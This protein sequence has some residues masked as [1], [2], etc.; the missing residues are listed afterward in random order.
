MTKLI[1]QYFLPGVRWVAGLG[2]G[3]TVLVKAAA[4]AEGAGTGRMLPSPYTIVTTCGMVTDIVREVAGDKAV[5][6]GLMGEGVDP[7]LYKPTRDDVARLLK[8][9]VVFYSGLMLEGRMTDTFLKVARRGTPVFAVTELLD[10]KFLLEPEEFQG[11]TDPHV[12]MDVRGWTQA[13]AVVARSL[14][15]V[16][17]RHADH[18]RRRAAAYMARLAE[19]DDYAR[20]TIASI[21]R[22]HRVLVTAHDA[23][24]YF[25]R[26]YD[27]EV[28]GVQGISTESEAGVGDI[29]RLV[30]FLVARKIPAIFVETSVSDKNVRALI[31]GCRARGHRVE[32]GGALFSD[33]MGAPGTYE[34]TYM[35]MIDHNVTTIARAL[36]GQ[37]PERGLHGK[38]RPK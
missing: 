19:L 8:A 16:D 14:S 3:L 30:D 5:V 9:D 6:T 13:V 20:R 27:I 31:E 2:L 17:P 32:I 28:R 12:W 1:S 23:F 24:N 25:G 34:G 11:H 29:N 35:G 36:G 7:H 33:A 26:A 18:Y 10:E 22:D 4:G 15:D 21:P 37:A 38:L